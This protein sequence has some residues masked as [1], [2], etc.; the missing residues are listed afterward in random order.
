M[1]QAHQICPDVLPPVR[2]QSD[3]CRAPSYKPQASSYKPRQSVIY[4]SK[5]GM[6]IW[7][8]AARELVSTIRS[9]P[10]EACIR[11]EAG[12]SSQTK[13][14]KYE[15]NNRSRVEMAGRTGPSSG[16]CSYACPEKSRLRRRE[17]LHSGTSPGRQTKNKIQR[18]RP[19]ASRRGSISGLSHLRKNLITTIAPARA[20]A[21]IMHLIPKR[22]AASFK[23]QA[24]S[25]KL[26]KV[27]AA[28]VKPQA[29][30]IKLQATSCKLFNI[31]SF[32]KFR[33]ARSERLY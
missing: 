28:S 16:R 7:S 24:S 25:S 19:D 5:M 4:A 2:S 11:G 3:W 20:G 21:I 17:D 18:R 29:A 1:L 31:F 8:R 9:K 26:L 6:I 10:C 13:G 32:V 33:D 15:S 14:E 12:G 23:Q 27:Q 22:Q 30:S